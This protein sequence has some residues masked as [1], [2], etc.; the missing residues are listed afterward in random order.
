[1]IDVKLWSLTKDSNDKIT[2]SELDS[3]IQ[4]ETEQQLEDLI[5]EN[6]NLLMDGLKL[7]GRQTPTSTGA[8]DLLGVDKDGYL[9]VFE[10]KRGKLPREAVTQV[11]DYASYLADL[12][13]ESLCQH[14]TDRSGSYGIEKIDEFEPEL[15]EILNTVYETWEN[16]SSGV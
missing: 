5:V 3:L 16:R 14:I 10:L 15:K 6:P 9:I 7:V 4:T 13:R 12:D 11:I 1:M 2:P 8:L